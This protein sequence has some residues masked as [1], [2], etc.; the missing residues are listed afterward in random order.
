MSAPAKRRDPEGRKAAILDAALTVIARDGV[1]R[2]SHRA[3]AK[4]ANVP[5]GSTTYY[6]PSREALVEEALALY[7]T[8][9][10]DELA[11]WSHVLRDEGNLA[12]GIARLAHEY[13]ADRER[14][15]VEYELYVAAARSPQ[16]RPAAQAWI[17][18][19]RAMLTPWTGRRSAIA[20]GALID[21]FVAEAISTSEAVS[22]ADLAAAIAPHLR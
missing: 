14:A 9:M 17:D 3:I 1:A 12:E 21:G 22:Q 4:E 15:L 13:I 8:R 2:T 16:V 19:V 6:F 18:G 20:I 7:T 5:L 10:I 11:R